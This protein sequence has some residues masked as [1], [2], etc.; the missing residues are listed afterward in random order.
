MAPASRRTHEFEVNMAGPRG[1]GKLAPDELLV[2]FRRMARG[3]SGC[4]DPRS[5]RSILANLPPIRRAAGRCA[6][7]S[8]RLR[9][10]LFFAST[11]W[12]RSANLIRVRNLLRIR[13]YDPRV[14]GPGK[15][16]G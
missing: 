1:R 7:R 10:H 3:E 6:C 5:D 9:Y 14:I 15:T 8:T 11:F 16:G 12:A 2:R 4:R 13:V